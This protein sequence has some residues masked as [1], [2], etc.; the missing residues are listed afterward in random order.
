MRGEDR[1]LELQETDL[2]ID[3][4]EARRGEIESGSAVR[5]ARDAFEHAETRVGELRLALDGVAREQRQFERDIDT[6]EQ[7][8]AAEEKRMYDGSIVNQ[9]ELQALQ[10]EIGSL[11]DRRSRFEDE[12]LVRM[13]QVEA[14]EG[15][16]GSAEGEMASARSRLDAT[17]QESQGELDTIVSELTERRA[18]RETLTPEIDDELLSLYE[19]LRKTKKGVGAAALVDGNCQGC[20]QTISSV[21]LNK[22]KHTD[23]I[24]RCEHCRRILIVA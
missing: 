20:H 7:K 15:E 16:I 6:L 17:G 24:K 23:A 9:K 11:G 13:E 5:A 1:L 3:R 14:L 2:A 8:R 12:L 22:L 10:H 21:E 18:T 4:L 19:D